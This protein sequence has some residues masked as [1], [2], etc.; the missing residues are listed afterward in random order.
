MENSRNASVKNSFYFSVLS[1][2]FVFAVMNLLLCLVGLAMPRTQAQVWSS[3]M[4]H[5]QGGTVVSIKVPIIEQIQ[6]RQ[7]S[8]F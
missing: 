6:S 4:S 8:V 1:T 5:D 7:F 2:W 3:A